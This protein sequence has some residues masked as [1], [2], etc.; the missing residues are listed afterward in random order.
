[1]SPM[2]ITG[3]PA[4][5]PVAAPEAAPV[6][7]TRKE[8]ALWL[9]EKMVPGTGVNNLSLAFATDWRLDPPIMRRTLDLLLARYEILR[10]V[11]S[12]EGGTLTRR[13]VPAGEPVALDEVDLPYAEVDAALTAFVGK[14][15][16]LDGGSLV[17][18]RVVHTEQGD[19]FCLAVHH[20]IFDALSSSVLLGDLSTV[21]IALKRGNELPAAVFET[22]PAAQDVAPTAASLAFWRTQLR[23]FD[24]T[25]FGLWVGTE[26]GDDPTL[27]GGTVTRPL[28]PE[29]VEAVRR[30]QK[31]LRAPEAVILLAVYY[32]LLAQHGAGPDLVVGSPVN[33]RKPTELTADRKS[34][35]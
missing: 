31:E 15:F 22:V 11:F 30:L 35:V 28:P 16:A 2:T 3:L 4:P 7:A 8:Q 17:R 5:A 26:P 10:T 14:P 23:Y 18:A 32:L 29:A 6:A 12:D 25:N 21:Y 13:V 1:M 24:E 20:L 27:A 33:S 34:V 9:L 19:V